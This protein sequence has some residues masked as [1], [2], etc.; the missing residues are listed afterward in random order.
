MNEMLLLPPVFGVA[1]LVCALI[2]YFLITKHPV[3]N[4]AIA[5]I[6][7]A[8]HSGAMVFMHREYKLLFLF[9]LVLLVLLYF[10]LG[11]N[12][13][14]AFAAGAICSALAGYIG[15]FT[16]TKANVRTT[17]AAHD[18]GS[19][20]A[21]S[22][23]FM[24]GS[25]MGLCVAAMGLL[26]LGLLYYFFGSDP[27]T[28]HAIHGFGMGA[29]T[30]ALF[31]RVGGGIFTKSADVG[32]DLVGKLEA[33][34]PEDDPR[35]PGVIADNV[36]D[37]VGDVAGMG[38]DIFESYCGSMIATIAIASTMTLDMMGA[39][40]SLMFLPLAL[41]SAGLI[42]SVLGIILVN[43]LSS[44]K[45]DVALRA[46]TMSA[47]ILFIIVAHFVIS[48]L[49]ISNNV[50]WAV[51]SGAV[52]GIIIGLVTEYYTASTPVHRIAKSGETGAATVMITGLSVGMQSVVLPVLTICA[53]IYVSTSLVGLYGVGIAAVGMLATVGITMAI[54]AYGPVADNA[55]GIAEMGGLGEETRKIT[56]S[57]D[58]LGNTTAAIGKGFAIGAAALAALA[59]IAA[60]IETMT[61]HDAAFTL[62]LGNPL[63]LI[64]MFIGGAIPFLIA[65]ITMTA[66]GDAA[67]EMI[68]EIRR[69]FKEIKGLMEGTAEPDT[70]RCIDI[71]TKAALKKMIL[72]GVIAVAAPPVVGFGL[73]AY[74]L[75]GM[76]G[77]ALLGCVLMALM[78]ANAGGAWDNAKKYVEKGNYGGKGS[79]VHAATVV[80][81]TVGDPFKDTSGPAMNILINVMAI[82]S[83]VIAPL[84]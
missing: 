29:S 17:Q 23:A 77:G 70:G 8:I 58:E 22:I 3:T 82:V 61:L 12:T 2:I 57:L 16:A 80:G 50:W 5:K 46:G 56:D 54:D 66:V 45:P 14:I 9:A 68:Q 49:E 60:F 65:S 33:G 51:I 83:L 44:S 72:P 30:V 78:M 6:A 13:A 28:A 1:G 52:G 32:A 24:G 34:I 39:R 21:L 76:L 69:Q 36:G 18:S 64:G 62:N 26:G 10:S 31:S 4:A 41:A 35:N 37:N 79:D 25:V 67:F 40:E 38:S 43:L 47:A 27:E 7:D 74:A 55:G 53:I 75:G 48:Y 73:G 63:V 15:M 84:L 11:E 19:A 42:C 20:K 81:D 71:A 59:I